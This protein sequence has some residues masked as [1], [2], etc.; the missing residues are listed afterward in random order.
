MGDQEDPGRVDAM[1]RRPAVDPIIPAA[2]RDLLTTTRR[3]VLIAACQDRPALRRDFLPVE[4]ARRLVAVGGACTGLT[5]ALLVA[6]FGTVPL[7]VGV[8]LLQQPTGWEYTSNHYA[9]VLAQ[10]VALVTTVVLG[11]RIARYGQ[12]DGKVPAAVAAHEHHGRYL[13]GA[14]LDARSRVLLRRAQ[15]AVDAVTSAQ[16]CVAGLVD[17]AATRVALAAQEWEIAVTLHEQAR[18][19]ARRS[20]LA[21]LG[22]G[23]L[24]AKLLGHHRQAARLADESIAARVAALERYAAEVRQADAAY[25][26]WQQTADLAELGDQHLD[27]VARTAADEHG[28]AE[29]ES[30]SQDARAIRLVLREARR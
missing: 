26:E 24:G 7:A 30:M 28:I 19:R 21:D 4:P 18:L 22:A 2:D 9:L 27:L 17:S 5:A 15:D 6:V 16:V 23:P 29:L 8:L 1:L 13:T 20:E 25:R 12:P 14:D 3:P 11:V 10:I